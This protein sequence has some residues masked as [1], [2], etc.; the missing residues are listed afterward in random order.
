M[1]P[2]INIFFAILFGLAVFML[3][4]ALTLRLRRPKPR[5]GGLV[6]RREEETLI[7]KDAPF[8]LG[9][10][11]LARPAANLGARLFR[12]DPQAITT[13]LRRSGWRYQSVAEFYGSKV[14]NAVVGFVAG[15]G[16]AMLLQLPFFVVI[17][18][19]IAFGVLGLFNAD[20]EVNRV[21]EKRRKAI[22]REMAWTLDRIAI[23]METGSAI[24][25]SLGDLLYISQGR[26]G[27]FTAILREIVNDLQNDRNPDAI[28]EK[29]LGAAPE[30]PELAN[31]MQ[32]MR[33]NLRGQPIVPQLKGLAAAMRDEL[34][35]DIENRRQAAEMKIIA[36]TS[37][38]VL[39]A[40]L[41]AVAGPVVL[42]VFAVLR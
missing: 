39:P 2:L 27:L 18:A 31:F 11:S 30:L 13:K 37:G 32:L 14:L 34:T 8:G 40:L 23:M 1:P 12:A 26:G 17:L 41:V 7:V 20:M 42:Q 15:V 4:S 38:V 5:V 6:E 24:T 33:V 16:V 22:Y 35:N 28:T 25:T 9:K 10:T 3:A 29:I 36:I 21:I 19:A